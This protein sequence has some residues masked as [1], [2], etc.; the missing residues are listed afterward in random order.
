MD[1]TMFIEIPVAIADTFA[2]SVTIS[3]IDVTDDAAVDTIS[4]A[5]NDFTFAFSFVVFNIF[6]VVVGVVL[7]ADNSY[8]IAVTVAV[9]TFAVD[10][11]LAI[12]VVDVVS[13]FVGFEVR[14]SF[15]L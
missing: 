10:I 9:V 5:L 13:F 15:I 6:I 4:V 1:F 12:V 8:P 14:F 2:V 3:A 11:S 7:E